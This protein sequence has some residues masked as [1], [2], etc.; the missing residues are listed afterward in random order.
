MKQHLI[1][2]FESIWLE[3]E[4]INQIIDYTSWDIIDEELAVKNAID[5]IL[6]NNEIVNNEIEKKI[7]DIDLVFLMNK[8]EKL[9]AK[10]KRNLSKK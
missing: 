9:W 2:F 5:F 10:K 8:L 6:Q 3:K 1:S 7:L 4:N